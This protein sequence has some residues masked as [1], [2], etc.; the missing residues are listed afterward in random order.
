MGVP[1]TNAVTGRVTVCV[2]GYMGLS[3]PF[4]KPSEESQTLGVSASGRAPSCR[5]SAHAPLHRG[6]TPNNLWP[7]GARTGK[8]QSFQGLREP[9]TL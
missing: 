8:L 5:I 4:A 2:P 1:Q 6:G 9:E 3:H 7:A